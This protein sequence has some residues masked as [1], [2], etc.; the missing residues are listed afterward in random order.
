MLVLFFEVLDSWAFV[1]F[2]SLG[3]GSQCLLRSEL[4]KFDGFFLVT[5]VVGV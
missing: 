2:A 5:S 3:I 4:K 1:D